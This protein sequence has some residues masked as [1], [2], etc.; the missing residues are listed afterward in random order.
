MEDST[1]A[2]VA[3]DPEVRDASPAAAGERAGAPGSGTYGRL[4]RL[5]AL[6]LRVFFRRVEVVGLENVPSERG[7][8][9]VAWHPN[10]LVDPALIVSTFPRQVVFGARHGLFRLPLLG[11]LI[12]AFG[13]VPIYRRGEAGEGAGEAHRARNE[14]SLGAL[15][16]RIAAGS[17]SALFPEGISHDAP[18]LQE[19]RTGAARL[20]YGARAR[21]PAGRPAPVVIPVGLHYDHKRVFRSVALVV[22]HPPLALPAELDVTPAPDEDPEA[23]RALA[24]GLTREIEGALEAAVLPT[25]SWELHRLFHRARKLVRAER[26]SRAG[27]E[28]GEPTMDEK[29][30]GLARIWVGYRERVRTRPAEVTALRKRVERY[31]RDLRTLGIADHELDQPPPIFNPWLLLVL[32]SQVVSVFLLLPP[33]LLIGYAVNLPPAALLSFVAHLAGKEDK[34][35]ASIKLVGGVVLFPLTWALWAA[36][37]AWGR[38]AAVA[39][40]PRLPGSPLPAAALA[41]L[42]GVGGGVLML[43]YVEMAMATWRALRVRLTRGRRARSMLRLRVARGRICDEILAMAEGIE[44]PGVVGEDGRVRRVASPAPHASGT[45]AL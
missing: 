42:L 16:D 38:G 33:F 11:P 17:F 13:T 39:L 44:L 9:L 12:R 6:L 3:G 20:Y 4:R 2:T 23:V 27:A 14:E 19:L 10:G 35:V 36:L 37:A 45:G 43:L 25:E 41:V 29:V 8:I 24:R 28:P 1:L 40:F 18:F 21:T 26:A 22:F 7:G 5:L 15:A 31:D 34:D 30:V 32:A